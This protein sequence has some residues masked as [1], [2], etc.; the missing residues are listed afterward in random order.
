MKYLIRD[1][2]VGQL[3]VLRVRAVMI[4]F[5]RFPFLLLLKFGL[6]LGD[7][8]LHLGVIGHHAFLDVQHRGSKLLDFLGAGL[9]DALDAHSLQPVLA[10]SILVT[11]E[12]VV[13][14]FD[15][16]VLICHRFKAGA[17]DK[18]T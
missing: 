13:R 10:K 2:A 9:A 17:F 14:F 8:L 11:I 4:V 15:L 3:V 7:L 18:F 12:A 1:I 16:G 5:V 6:Q